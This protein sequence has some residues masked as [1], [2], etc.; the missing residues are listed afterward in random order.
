MPTWY[1]TSPQIT[2]HLL[3]RLSQKLVDLAVLIDQATM[4]LKVAKALVRPEIDDPD[5]WAYTLDERE[6]LFRESLSR[7]AGLIK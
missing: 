4:N 1:N 5:H 3:L 7:L 2:C 6:V